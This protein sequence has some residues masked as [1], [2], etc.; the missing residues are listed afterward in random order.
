MSNHT[1]ANTIPIRELIKERKGVER[2][3]D[4]ARE[5]EFDEIL[6]L[7]WKDGRTYMSNSGLDDILR[8]IGAMEVL[9]F[10]LQEK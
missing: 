9:K 7:G 8:V 10:R 4:L 6:I 5:Q 1:Q 3:L 2:T